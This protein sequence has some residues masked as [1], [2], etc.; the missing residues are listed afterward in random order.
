MMVCLGFEPM[1]SEWK[2]VM[3]P[4]SKSQIQEHLGL[5]SPVIT[6]LS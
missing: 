4:L 2:A 6:N 3:N 1:A 5:Y